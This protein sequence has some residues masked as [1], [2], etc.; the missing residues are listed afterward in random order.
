MARNLNRQRTT[1]PKRSQILNARISEETRELLEQAAASSQRTISAEAEHQLQRALSDWGPGPTHAVMQIIGIAV[2]RLVRMR[3]DAKGKGPGW[4][5][6]KQA[7]WWS[8]PYLYSQA[9]QVVVAAF[10][11]FRPPGAPLEQLQELLDAGG[12]RQGRFTI[13]GLLDE[14]RQIDDTMPLDRATPYQRWLISVKHDLGMM[15][16]QPVIWGVTAEQARQ[17]RQLSGEVLEELIP[18]SRKIAKLEQAEQPVAAEDSR[19][20]AELWR[21]IATIR[22]GGTP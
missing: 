12:R 22:E 5:K 1:R 13:E 21:K 2:D 11:L 14:V 19:R 16:Y 9:A 17:Q 4:R 18:L 3:L 20:L 10:E 8:D 7:R 6:D 15:L